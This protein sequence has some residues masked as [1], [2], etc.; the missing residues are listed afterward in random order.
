MSYE[1]LVR[2]LVKYPR[3]MEIQTDMKHLHNFFA[4]HSKQSE[5]LPSIDNVRVIYDEENLE[6]INIEGYYV[7]DPFIL[8]GTADVDSDT[9][10]TPSQAM[11]V[12]TEPDNSDFLGFL[13]NLQGRFKDLIGAVLS[14][15]SMR[16]FHP[17]HVS[18]V[19]NYTDYMRQLAAHADA[20]ATGAVKSSFE[21]KGAAIYCPFSET[22][23]ARTEDV[24][25]NQTLFEKWK[26]GPF[27]TKPVHGPNPTDTA[28]VETFVGDAISAGAE[29]LQAVQRAYA[30]AADSGC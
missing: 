17:D 4:E 29:T 5:P 9:F 16:G 6:G 27:D 3:I 19:K 1:N 8:L 21:L 11:V 2:K 13:H 26:Q 18:I 12:N 7:K 24:T 23:Q 28:D 15:T 20:V 10:F 30:S 25:L 22:V 14:F